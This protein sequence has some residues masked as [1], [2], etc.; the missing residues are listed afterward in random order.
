MSKE[1]ILEDI[2]RLASENGGKPLGKEKFQR[3]T[4]IKPYH[5]NKYWVRFGDI[6]I[7]AGF[8][9]NKMNEAYPDELIIEKYIDLINEVGHFPTSTELN[10][11]CHNDDSFPSK[12]AMQRLGKK[13]EVAQKILNST[14]SNGLEKV[15]DICQNILDSD[16]P[17]LNPSDSSNIQI[18]EVYM[19]KHGNR[20]HYKIG[21]SK[22]GVRREKELG[23]LLPERVEKIHTI[24]TDD[25]SGVEAYWHNRF[26]DKRLNGEWFD[27]NSDDIKAFKR[28]RKIV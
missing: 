18:G 13:S 25:P 4:G 17:R 19:Y 7:E 12:N 5:W 3:E 27:L 8:K 20:N 14:L 9:P 22:D 15:I 21:R 11:K 16:K 6:L 10:F 23:P 28:W 2:K 1:K 24:P 26:K